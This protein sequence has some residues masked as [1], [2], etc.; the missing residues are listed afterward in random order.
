MKTEYFNYKIVEKLHYDVIRLWDTPN[1]HLWYSWGK[2]Y[3][4]IESVINF[5]KTWFY[6]EFIDKIT[7]LVF[8]INKN[9]IFANWNKRTSIAIGAFFLKINWYDYCV[10][11]FMIDMENISVSV[12]DNKI[13]K[14]LLKDIIYSITSEDDYN[15]ELK[16]EILKAIDHKNKTKIR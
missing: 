2:S 3:E 13:S 11:K 15:E 1:E 7:H 16:L 9:H 10:D 8:S 4:D 12:A 5:V 6:P 14:K